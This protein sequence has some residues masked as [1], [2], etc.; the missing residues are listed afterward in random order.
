[1]FVPPAKTTKPVTSPATTRDPEAPQR[2]RR[3]SA[4]AL[5]RAR[6][7]AGCY[8]RARRVMGFLYDRIIFPAPRGP[9]PAEHR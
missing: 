7:R 3:R 2:A 4:A 5:P 6:C 8:G 1:M 9:R